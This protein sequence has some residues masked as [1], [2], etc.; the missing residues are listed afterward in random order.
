MSNIK[1]AATV[2]EP[3]VNAEKGLSFGEQ[4]AELKARRALVR[5]LSA[6]A[7]EQR[8]KNRA[9]EENTKQEK[10]G[11]TAQISET[12][13]HFHT[14]GTIPE[15]GT[16]QW[17]LEDNE[18]WKELLEWKTNADME[19]PSQ[20]Q[21]LSRLYLS[22]LEAALKHAEG[23]NLT[24]QLDRLDTLLAE[25]LN[26]VMRQNLRQ[27]TSI[28]EETGQ[29]AALDS[30]RSSLYRQ[31][32]GRTISSQA[33]HTLFTQGGA[34]GRRTALSSPAASSVSGKGMIYQ[35][36][37]KQNARFQQTYHTQQTSWKEQ[38]RQRTE[39]IA[40]ARKGVAETSF[41]QGSA[42]SCSGKE[43]AR[44][45][46]FAAHIR[47]SGNLFKNPG[48][49]ARNEEVTGLLAA[50]MSIKGQ[51]YTGERSRSGSVPGAL[52]NAIEKIIDQYLARKGASN[53]YYHTLTAYKQTQNP[54]KAMEEGQDYA[55]RQ[56]REKQKEP[57]YEKSPHYSKN[58]GFFRT[59]LKGLSPEKEFALGVSLLQKDWQTFLYAIGSRP[60]VSLSRASLYSP[61]GVLAGPGT[62]RAG[63]GK[64]A[65][66]L[67]FGAGAAILIGVLAVIGFRLF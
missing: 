5:D 39:T 33:A 1:A 7:M 43:L 66:K 2:P 44:A 52:E 14:D 4:P 24:I 11:D 58:A 13:R 55:F 40:N 19:L 67:L 57:G 26:L 25:K 63:H 46:R 17:V 53:V 64:S 38:I 51:V 34:I 49:S 50:V 65:E 23:E 48:I 15:D 41:R 22:L 28:L 29:S 6:A 32:A 60:Q 42:V 61:W 37:G 16:F 21:D 3:A 35:A 27:L 10:S 20:L 8:E 18:H 9:S 56:F 30:I 12:R 59:L 45:D 31:T 62:H 47:G 36:S 54:K